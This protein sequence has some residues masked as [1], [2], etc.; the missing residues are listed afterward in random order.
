MTGFFPGVNTILSQIIV[1]RKPHHCTKKHAKQPHRAVLF[2]ARRRTQI[3]MSRAN[4]PPFRPIAPDN[5]SQAKAQPNT[6]ETQ[7][8]LILAGVL[9]NIHSIPEALPRPMLY[10]PEHRRT[11]FAAVYTLCRKGKFFSPF[12]RDAQCCLRDSF[13]NDHKLA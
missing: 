9:R 11:R 7:L 13:R 4:R 3:S 2:P 10:G 12:Q 1:E 8:L 6:P 5:T